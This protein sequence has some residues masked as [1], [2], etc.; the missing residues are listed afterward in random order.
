MAW[1]DL[2]RIAGDI[3]YRRVRRERGGKRYFEI[4]VS[5][6]FAR[7]AVCKT[8]LLH[9]KTLR[10]SNIGCAQPP[11]PGLLDASP[12]CPLLTK[13]GN[14]CAVLNFI[15]KQSF[16][17]LSYRQTISNFHIESKRA[18]IPECRARRRKNQA[19]VYGQARQAATRPRP[20]PS[21]IQHPASFPINPLTH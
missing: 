9:R 17:V 20:Y 10:Y 1:R 8:A 18:R 15:K 2:N 11:L 16:A 13:V 19:S 7:S 14:N 12:G 4:Y 21:S 3:F 6:T 5:A